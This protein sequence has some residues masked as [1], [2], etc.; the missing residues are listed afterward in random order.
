MDIK[1]YFSEV[2]NA[3]VHEPH[4]AMKIYE[5]LL[6]DLDQALE[7]LNSETDDTLTKAEKGIKLTKEVVGRLRD[8]VLE[9]GFVNKES[10]T[11]FFKYIKPQVLSKLIYFIKIFTIES[12]RPRSS[13]GAQ[14]QYFEEHIDRLQDYFNDNLEFYHY[15]RRG[16]TI[17][18]DQY[19]LR[20]K[21]DIRL[22][23]DTFHFLTDEQ[24]STSHD[25]S[26]A[27]I[28]AYDMLIAYLRKEIQKLGVEQGTAKRM[29]LNKPVPKLFWTSNKVD[30]IELIYALHT[31]GAINRGTADI[32]EIALTFETILEMDLGDYYRTYLEIRS[33]KIR[34][35]K[36]L[37]KLKNSLHQHMENLDA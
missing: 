12:K 14:K 20:G 34:R 7:G 13:Y 30:L 27:M 29:E 10:E 1:I 24:F 3:I 5:D 37:D 16:A 9:K 17:F 8:H 19:F 15:Y 21:A 18:D 28:I 32:K 2:L 26:V 36:F 22:H 35:T 11:H 25:S 23:P 31:S 6:I 33:R 4:P